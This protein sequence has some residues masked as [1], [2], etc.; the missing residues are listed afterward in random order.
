MVLLAEKFMHFTGY[1]L[2]VLGC[3][4]ALCCFMLVSVPSYVLVWQANQHVFLACV[5]Y[6]KTSGNINC[7]LPLY[8]Q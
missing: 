5:K 6:S 2:G 4:I 1:K 8:N 7:D 3:I